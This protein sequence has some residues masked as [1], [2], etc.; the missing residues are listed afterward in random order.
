MAKGVLEARPDIG[1]MA[2]LHGA[3]AGRRFQ[4][5]IC[6]KEALSHDHAVGAVSILL[7]VPPPFRCAPDCRPPHLIYGYGPVYSKVVYI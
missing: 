6:R 4:N 1:R 5:A 3:P 7:L 2:D